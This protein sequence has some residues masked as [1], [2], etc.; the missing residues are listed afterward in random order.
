MCGVLQVAWAEAVRVGATRSSEISGKGN[1]IISMIFSAQKFNGFE[2]KKNNTSQ[3][4]KIMNILWELEGINVKI[5]PFWLNTKIGTDCEL[6][7]MG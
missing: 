3:A 1:F 4:S 6:Q 7:I 5:F 2:N